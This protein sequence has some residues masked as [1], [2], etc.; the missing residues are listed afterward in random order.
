MDNLELKIEQVVDT[1]LEDYRSDRDID[2]MEQQRQ[3]DKDV[4]IDMIGK[5]RNIVFPGYFRERPTG[6]IM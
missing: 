1:I 2:K 5:L 3:P 4:I 6:A